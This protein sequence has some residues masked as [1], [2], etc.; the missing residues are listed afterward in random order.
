M[1][2]PYYFLKV[3]GVITLIRDMDGKVREYLAEPKS[4]FPNN[5]MVLLESSELK[6]KCPIFALGGSQCCFTPLY[7][8]L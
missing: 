5:R 4:A 3:P 2:D 1:E 7:I 8:G 6:K